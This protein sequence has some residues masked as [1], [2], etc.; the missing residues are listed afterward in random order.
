MCDLMARIFPG[1]PQNV[2]K[3]LA[4]DEILAFL[5]SHR[6]N[7]N[8]V[9][10]AAQRLFFGPAFVNQR[11]QVGVA[12]GQYFDPGIAGPEL[13]IAWRDWRQLQMLAAKPN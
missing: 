9:R 4:D 5:Q 7:L 13:P 11:Q 1:V 3:P 2:A 8:L 12:R 6:H 10:L